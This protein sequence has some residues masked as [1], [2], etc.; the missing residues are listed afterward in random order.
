[1]LKE[2]NEL[3]DVEG[4]HLGP[5]NIGVRLEGCTV[6]PSTVPKLLAARRHLN[7]LTNRILGTDTKISGFAAL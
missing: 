1:V 5:P 3:R 2:V 7:V 6:Q 4:L